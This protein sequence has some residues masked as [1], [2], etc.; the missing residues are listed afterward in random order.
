MKRTLAALF[1]VGGAAT[2]CTQRYHPPGAS[3]HA[4]APVAGVPE[5]LAPSDLDP[6][7]V[8]A[9]VDGH[10]ITVKDLD[11]EI[12]P[13]LG[14]LSQ[15]FQSEKLGL[16]RQALD[17]VLVMR[18]VDAE[19]KKDGTTQEAW[20]KKHVE[21]TTPEASVA[22]ARKFYDENSAR[23][24]GQSFD[25]E[26]PNIVAFLTHQ[27]REQAARKLFDE[28][29]SRAKIEV[30]LEELTASAT[31]GSPQGGPSSP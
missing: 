21:G 11:K 26:K 17:E 20:L 1:L 19:A 4:L 18:L 14:Q 9:T 22:D 10:A 13:Q 3:A 15:Q 12:S 25:E 28:L 16:R 8:V 29:K 5:A 6:A 23:M 7:R 24:G 2:A 30:T 31:A 27:K